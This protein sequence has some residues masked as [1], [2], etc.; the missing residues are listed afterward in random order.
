MTAFLV[1]DFFG[2]CRS[3]AVEDHGIVNFIKLWANLHRFEGLGR[4]SLRDYG[5]AWGCMKPFLFLKFLGL[6]DQRL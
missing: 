5:F 3:K 2:F 1:S 4:G 6:V